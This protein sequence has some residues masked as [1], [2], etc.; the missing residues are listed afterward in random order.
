VVP[1]SSEALYR[2]T[3]SP[4]YALAA[5]ERSKYLLIDVAP[6]MDEVEPVTRVTS[7]V[8]KLFGVNSSPSPPKLCFVPDV[9][10]RLVY[11]FPMTEP[12]DSSIV[13]FE[14]RVSMYPF[15]VKFP[16]LRSSFS[17]TVTGAGSTAPAAL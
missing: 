14:P 3:N 8:I 13:A 17:S 1:F 5:V 7:T 6:L 9:Q 2:N 10:G 12:P 11:K 4:L 15:V 16:E